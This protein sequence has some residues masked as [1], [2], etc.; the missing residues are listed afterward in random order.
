MVTEENNPKLMENLKYKTV[1][2]LE[3]SK[4]TTLRI[5]KVNQIYGIPVFFDKFINVKSIMMIKG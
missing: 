5:E 4:I 2:K 3:L 1:K